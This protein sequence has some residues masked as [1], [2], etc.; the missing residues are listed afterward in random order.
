MSIALKTFVED[1][2]FWFSIFFASSLFSEQKLTFFFITI[3]LYA[4]I[5]LFLFIEFI[6]AI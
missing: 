4:L 3:G 6:K 2:L 1:I 5:L